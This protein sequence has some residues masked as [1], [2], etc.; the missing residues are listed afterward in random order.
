MPASDHARRGVRVV[1]TGMSVGLALARPALGQAPATPEGPPAPAD[2]PQA[3]PSRTLVEAPATPARP[4]AIPVNSRAPPPPPRPV[5][6]PIH[7]PSPITGQLYGFIEERFNALSAEPNRDRNADGSP[8]RSQSEVDLALPS[9]LI[10]AQEVSIRI[11]VT[12]STW[13]RSTTT[14]R[15]P[16]SPSACGTL[17]SK[18]RSWGTLSIS[19]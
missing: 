5:A 16:T 12:I 13:A 14:S 2:M 11:I 1:L 10:M 4:A 18:P 7:P 17:S 6:A 9:F 3:R 8:S 15:P 19:G